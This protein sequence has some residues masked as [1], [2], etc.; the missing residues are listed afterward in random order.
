M[1]TYQPDTFRGL[2]ETTEGNLEVEKAKD[3][4]IADWKKI[5]KRVREPIP[6]RTVFLEK[7]DL[8]RD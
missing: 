4:A 5:T 2:P 3:P 1:A 8:H 6:L 7:L